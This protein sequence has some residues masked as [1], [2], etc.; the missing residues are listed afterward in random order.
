MKSIR[1][2]EECLRKSS[3]YCL[4]LKAA[5]SGIGTNQSSYNHI[6][7]TEWTWTLS[8]HMDTFILHRHYHKPWNCQNRN[9]N[10]KELIKINTVSSSCY[11]NWITTYSSKT[12]EQYPRLSIRECNSMKNSKKVWKLIYFRNAVIKK[13]HWIENP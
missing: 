9:I 13:L 2:L 1:I 7:S 10:L 11:G 12:I 5:D 4:E 3:Q 8:Y 6:E